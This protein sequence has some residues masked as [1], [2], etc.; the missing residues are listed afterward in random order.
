MTLRQTALAVLSATSMVLSFTVSSVAHA[1]DMAP[2][3][4]QE[5]LDTASPFDPAMVEKTLISVAEVLQYRF[6]QGG[7]DLVERVAAGPIPVIYHSEA[8]DGEKLEPF[9]EKWGFDPR[10]IN[11]FFPT[12]EILLYDKAKV[13]NLAHELVHFIQYNYLG[14]NTDRDMTG[15]HA[16]MMAVYVQKHFMSTVR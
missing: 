11:I 15:D 12:D 9:I 14:M 13:H 16:E 2:G 8:Y 1:K 7:D 5:I 10:G 3:F 4:D 6:N